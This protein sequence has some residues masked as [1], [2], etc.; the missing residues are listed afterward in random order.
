M[1]L[2]IYPEGTWKTV[3]AWFCLMR[4][5]SKGY[6]Q[7]LQGSPTDVT[8]SCISCVHA[9]PNPQVYALNDRSRGLKTSEHVSSQK[10]KFA[11]IWRSHRALES[12]LIP[13]V[14]LLNLQSNTEQRI[15]EKNTQNT[16]YAKK[17]YPEH[18]IA[19]ILLLRE[20]CS[21]ASSRGQPP[22]EQSSITKQDTILLAGSLYPLYMTHTCNTTGQYRGF[23]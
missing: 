12:A 15:C 5:Y 1:G 14:M 9:S 19:M 8:T 2:P 18:R 22:I 17:I 21:Q 10:K 11:K 7:G 13:L 16:E 23:Y 6:P 3:H 4:Y 20:K